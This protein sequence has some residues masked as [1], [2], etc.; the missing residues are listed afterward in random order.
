MTKMTPPQGGTNWRLIG[1]GIVAAATGVGAGDLVATLIAGSL[2]GY[3]LIWAAVL[4][5]LVKIALAEGAARYHLATGTTIFEGWRS[6]GAWTSWYFGPYILIW[7]FIYGATAMSATALPLAALFPVLPLTG[8]AVIV[9]LT[10]FLFVAL[11]RYAVFET[12]M[13]ILV[14][15]M[16]VIVV[17]LAV[18]V[19]PDL[20][21]LLSGLAPR[22]PEGSVFYTLGLIGG[23]GGTITTA[24]YGYWVNAKGWRD[25]S[26]IPMMRLDNRVAYAMTGL[27]VIAMLIVGAELLHSAQ[28]ALAGGGE[29]LLQLEDV[30]AARFGPVIATLFLV[31]F[32][33][34][35][36]SS[37]FGVWHGV[38]L[39][40]SDFVE[41]LQG[42]TERAEHP[43]RKWPFRA[44]LAWLTFPPMLLLFLGRP[45]LLV[46]LYGVFGAFFMP[47]LA[48]TLLVLLNSKRMPAEHRSGWLSNGALIGAALLFAVLC[49]QQIVEMAAA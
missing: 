32:A 26:W 31:G 45:F 6:L 24:A 12:V 17:G 4:G 27:F 37:V 29:G 36:L 9:G 42:R 49:V 47:F 3:A 30:L 8:W 28:I 21:A 48:V 40:F 25:A 16:F 34:T 44:Y 13:K 2:Y 23:V 14:G 18:L 35:A 43:E 20:P 11:N 38:S 19:L 1:P 41:H 46:I 10:A 5:C 33:A 22:A 39:L 15:V 7:G